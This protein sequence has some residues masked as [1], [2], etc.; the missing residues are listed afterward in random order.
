VASCAFTPES[1]KPSL[2]VIDRQ[3]TVNNETSDWPNGSE[4]RPSAHH[5]Y[6]P[7]AQL[8]HSVEE[9]EG[10]ISMTSV[11]C[12]GLFQMKDYRKYVTCT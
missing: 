2:T 6:K 9:I 10:E 11:N 3:K 4:W 8:D 7:D 5:F 1:S 12:P